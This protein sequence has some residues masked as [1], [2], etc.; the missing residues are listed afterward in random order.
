[1]IFGTGAQRAQ[2]VPIPTLRLARRPDH[3]IGQAATTTTLSVFPPTGTAAIKWQP[4]RPSVKHVSSQPVRLP[5]PAPKSGQR[6]GEPMKRLSFLIAFL[7][8]LNWS[9]PVRAG[10]DILEQCVPATFTIKGW[11]YNDFLN[12]EKFRREDHISAWLAGFA[13]GSSLKTSICV[14]RIIDC[15]DNTSK[16]QRLVMVEKRAQ[17]S[18]EKWGAGHIGAQY[19][20]SSFVEPCLKGEIPLKKKK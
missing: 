18:P 19:V 16:G 3:S 2:E 15:M 10:P 14:D 20:Y 8:A 12:L 5:V 1:M 7:I 9:G 11:S 6:T 13:S 4:S 17:D